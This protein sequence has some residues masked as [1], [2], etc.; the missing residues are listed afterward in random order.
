MASRVLFKNLHWSRNLLFV[1]SVLYIASS[2]QVFQFYPSF[3]QRDAK[4]EANVPHH[5]TEMCYILKIILY[6]KIDIDLAIFFLFSS[7]KLNEI[8]LVYL[9]L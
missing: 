8:L 7:Y 1:Y 4:L 5:V 6:I 9:F 3:T 2:R